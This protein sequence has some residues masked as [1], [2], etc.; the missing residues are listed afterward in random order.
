MRFKVTKGLFSNISDAV[1]L[2]FFLIEICLAKLFLKK[3]YI[4]KVCFKTHVFIGK[5]IYIY[6][7]FLSV[8]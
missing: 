5:N 1:F 8:P 6:I 2:L 7:S 4:Q 3:N